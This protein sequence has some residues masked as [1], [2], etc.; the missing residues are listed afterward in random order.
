VRDLTVLFLHLLATIVRLA[1]PGGVRAVLAESVLVKQQLLILNRSRRRS[2]NLRLADR[3]VAGVCAL[4]MR[5]SRLVR[6]AIVLK[7]STLLRLV[8]GELQIA[9]GFRNSPSRQLSTLDESDRAIRL[10]Y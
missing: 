4:L 1:G 9:Q 7:P 10:N 8:H 3:V 2:P 6:S 5:P